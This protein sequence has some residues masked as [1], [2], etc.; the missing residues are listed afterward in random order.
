MGGERRVVGVGDVWGVV[1]RRRVGWGWFRG[2]MRGAATAQ[3]CE[4][5]CLA[6]RCIA[7]KVRMRA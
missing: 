1:K 7:F 5:V 4:A 6:L 2:C 3:P